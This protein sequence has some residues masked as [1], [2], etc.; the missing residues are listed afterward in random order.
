MTGE[1][2]SEPP[3]RLPA[4]DSPATDAQVTDDPANANAG[5]TDLNEYGVCFLAPSVSRASVSS[6]G[7]PH[8]RGHGSGQ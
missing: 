1:P 3:P 5:R 2:T 6:P 8:G 7:R 4:Q